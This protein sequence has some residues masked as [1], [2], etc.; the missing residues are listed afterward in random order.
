MQ[1]FA[2]PFLNLGIRV[3]SAWK[4]NAVPVIEYA[5]SQILLANKG[6]YQLTR[7]IRKNRESAEDF[8]T[9]FKGN[10]RAKVGILGDGA[11]GGG[12]IDELLRHNLNVFVYS[13]TMTSEQAKAKGVRLAGL[14]EIFSTCDVISNHLANNEETKGIIN[15]KLLL[16]LPDY[17]TF[18]N[19]GRGAQVDESALLEVLKKNRTLTAVLDVTYPELPERKS[20]LYTLDNVFL[21]PHIAGSNGFEIERLAVCMVEEYTRIIKNEPP[22][23][24]ITK[25]ML[26]KMA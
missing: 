16:S 3:C 19:T 17:A 25:K 7:L 4:A 26:E 23:Y 10:Y 11:I 1:C 13:I 12:V 20:E 9:H 8:F 22:I 14:E 15:G 6:F 21:T 18:I 5:V 24:E 2:R